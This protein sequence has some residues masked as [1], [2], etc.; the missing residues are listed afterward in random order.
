MFKWI[1]F[2]W[3][4]RQLKNY[5]GRRGASECVLA[6]CAALTEDQA[7]QFF[8]GCGYNLPRKHS[9]RDTEGVL[10][11]VLILVLGLICSLLLVD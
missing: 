8:K 9:E 2:T 3:M 5:S 4:P 1:K 11:L 7:R 10:C 6:G